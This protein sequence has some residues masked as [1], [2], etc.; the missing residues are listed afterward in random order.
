MPWNWDGRGA[1]SVDLGGNRGSVSEATNSTTW[2]SYEAAYLAKR[3][4]STS[5]DVDG[6]EEARDVAYADKYKAAGE[7]HSEPE[8]NAYLERIT[9]NYKQEA[10]EC[11][12]QEFNDWL[13]GNHE[14]N[15]PTVT[16][17]NAPG[18]MER[19]WVFGD[20]S[21]IR[22]GPGGGRGTGEATSTL[23][24]WSPTWWGRGAITHLPGVREYLREQKIKGD[25]HTFAMN[26]LAEFGPQNIDQAWA[27][28]KHWVKGR[29]ISEA[30]CLHE[31]RT[32][33][34]FHRAPIGTMKA[35]PFYYS[36]DMQPGTK[37]V[38]AHADA[39]LPGKAPSGPYT[40]YLTGG[41]TKV[42]DQSSFP[43]AFRKR[44]QPLEETQ[45][46]YGVLETAVHERVQADPDGANKFRSDWAIVDAIGDSIEQ[47][48]SLMNEA[49]Q[50]LDGTITDPG[51]IQRFRQ[52]VRD[53]IGQLRFWGVQ[54]MLGDGG[55]I[56]TDEESYTPYEP[57]ENDASDAASDPASESSEYATAVSA[58]AS[59]SMTRRDMIASTRDTLQ[60]LTDRV[61]ALIATPI[62]EPI[63]NLGSAS[64]IAE[65]VNLALELKELKTE[66]VLAKDKLSPP[67]SEFDEQSLHSESTQQPPSEQESASSKALSRYSYRSSSGSSAAA[68]NQRIINRAPKANAGIDS[69]NQRRY[70]LRARAQEPDPDLDFYGTLIAP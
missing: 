52:A 51:R 49:D 70:R 50:I 8:R 46:V 62:V 3:L 2:P 15:D 38:P 53:Q 31:T 14:A 24:A 25:E 18:Q 41:G 13:Q 5:R 48:S 45:S 60:R 66:M 42:V 7:I 39:G 9:A 6:Q 43:E 28:F 34:K 47:G 33:N 58:G 12:K 57:P 22:N 55:L 36:G 32:D 4:A 27:Y 59:S 23:N 21:G 68:Q 26:V 35:E 11:L 69:S 19:K 16:Y 20:K 17:P 67:P 40:A 61:V 65:R 54:H 44:L 30:T 64:Q 37:H 10:D 56:G 29:P 1:K 63:T